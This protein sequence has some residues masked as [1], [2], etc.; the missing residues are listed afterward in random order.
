MYG[1]QFL[2][3][4]YYALGSKLKSQL[5]LLFMGSTALFDIIH[6]S[7]CFGTIHVSH[8]TILANFYFYLPYF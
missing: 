6:M 8:Y 3:N 7:Y 1:S 5:I 4:S 2:K